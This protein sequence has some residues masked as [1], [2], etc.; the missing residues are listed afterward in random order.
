M[1]LTPDIM[2]EVF[3]IIECL[4]PLKNKLRFK[5]RN[6]CTVRNEIK[7]TAFLAPGYG[8]ICLLNYTRILHQTHLDQN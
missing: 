7:I 3:Y 1:K 8:T 6:I 5:S 2:N 4:Y